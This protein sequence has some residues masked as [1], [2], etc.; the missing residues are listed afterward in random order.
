M[1]TT[2]NL[3]EVNNIPMPS[4]PTDIVLTLNYTNNC[5]Y[6][7]CIEMKQFGTLEQ[8]AGTC[9]LQLGC[10]SGSSLSTGSHRLIYHNF[11]NVTTGCNTYDRHSLGTF[12]MRKLLKEGHNPIIFSN[13][14]D[15]TTGSITITYNEPN[16]NN[17]TTILALLGLVALSLLVIK[18]GHKHA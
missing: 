6:Y 17:D 13:G 4:I 3:K 7:S 5:G 14:C 12:D 16:I 1:Q 8:P 10:Q 11:I 15:H 2:Y 18:G 9:S